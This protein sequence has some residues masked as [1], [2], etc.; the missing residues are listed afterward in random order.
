MQLEDALGYALVVGIVLTILVVSFSNYRRH[1]SDPDLHDPV[2]DIHD[3]TH[4]E[5]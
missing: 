2:Y 5:E 1:R 3:T 4:T